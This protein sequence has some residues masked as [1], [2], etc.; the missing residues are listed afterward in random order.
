MTEGVERLAKNP[1][2][3]RAAIAAGL[4]VL[5][6]V[7]WRASGPEVP[8]V[9]SLKSQLAELKS[10]HLGLGDINVNDPLTDGETLT[11]GTAAV[12]CLDGSGYGVVRVNKVRETP[13]EYDVIVRNIGQGTLSLPAAMACLQKQT[14]LDIRIIEA[15]AVG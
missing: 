8:V 2:V 15:P 4:A 6:V 10:S 11:A 9:G 3:R 13:A 1:R 7:G 12:V 5:A 14:P